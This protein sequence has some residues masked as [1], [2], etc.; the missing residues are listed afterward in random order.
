M[1]LVIAFVDILIVHEQVQKF[2]ASI[3]NLFG[4]LVFWLN[5]NSLVYKTY[6]LIYKFL[7]KDLGFTFRND[8]PMHKIHNIDEIVIN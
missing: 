4:N 2:K 3:K 6:E 7:G 5:L 1:F 8:F